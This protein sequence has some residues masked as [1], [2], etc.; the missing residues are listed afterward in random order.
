MDRC[1][2]RCRAAGMVGARLCAVPQACALRPLSWSAGADV[3]PCHRALRLVRTP[4]R[5]VALRRDVERPALR[6]DVVPA[7]RG[8]RC[9]DRRGT[10]AGLST[11]EDHRLRA[12]LGRGAGRAAAGAGGRHARGGAGRRGWLPGRAAARRVGAAR[13][14][15]PAGG[16]GGA[17]A[18]AERGGVGQAA[19]AAPRAGSCGVGSGRRAWPDSRDRAGGIRPAF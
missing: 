9:S 18:V 19:G 11:G 15:R 8:G 10:G 1:S 2:F 17:A 6:R 4:G 3:G 5:W 14:A 13:A 16:G 12:G 7:E